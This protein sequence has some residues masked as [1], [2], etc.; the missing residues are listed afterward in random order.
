M[1]TLATIVTAQEINTRI[2]ICHRLLFG[3]LKWVRFAPRAEIRR[4]NVM[5]H[6]RFRNSFGNCTF[7]MSG[8]PRSRCATANG[9]VKVK[10]ATDTRSPLAR[11]PPLQK[12]I[13]SMFSWQTVRVIY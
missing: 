5:E 12:T 1:P 2:V 11:L 13:N 7:L 6:R 9:Y 8:T 4:S 10:K 3:F